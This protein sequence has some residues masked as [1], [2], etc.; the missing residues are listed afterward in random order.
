VRT[1]IGSLLG[2]PY[3][4][5]FVIHG[6]WDDEQLLIRSIRARAADGALVTEPYGEAKGLAG[7]SKRRESADRLRETHAVPA[8][9]E[10][11]MVVLRSFWRRFVG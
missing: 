4:A 1:V 2:S 3:H 5:S 6:L 10:C 11:S 9:R 7:T 8:A